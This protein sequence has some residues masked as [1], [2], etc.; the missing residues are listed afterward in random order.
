LAFVMQIKDFTD[1]MKGVE[2]CATCV[3]A[4][5]GAKKLVSKGKSGVQVNM[6]DGRTRHIHGFGYTDTQDENPKVPRR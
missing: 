2:G 3:W 5:K 4:I 1:D 6:P